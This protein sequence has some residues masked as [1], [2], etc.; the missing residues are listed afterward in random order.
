MDKKRYISCP[1]SGQFKILAGHPFSHNVVTTAIGKTADILERN[2]EII[3]NDYVMS[4]SSK[5]QVVIFRKSNMAKILK[6]DSSF[7]A[8]VAWVQIVR[9][10]N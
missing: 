3:Y 4:K 10:L 1:V 9:V 5:F 7:Q 8:A 2:R 6:F